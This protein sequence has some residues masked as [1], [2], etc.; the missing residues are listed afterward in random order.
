MMRTTRV[1]VFCVSGIETKGNRCDGKYLY[2]FADFRNSVMWVK[3]R[4]DLRA[5]VFAWPRLA[6]PASQFCKQVDV[7]TP[8]PCL[9]SAANFDFFPIFSQRPTSVLCIST[10]SR[11][12][13]NVHR[14][15]LQSTT[16]WDGEVLLPPP[17][18]P[19]SARPDVPGTPAV[20][21]DSGC[22]AGGRSSVASGLAAVSA[23]A[24]GGCGGSPAM[25][26]LTATGSRL[27]PSSRR[28]CTRSRTSGVGGGR[29]NAAQ[30]AEGHGERGVFGVRASMFV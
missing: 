22:P 9:L 4:C 19:A 6:S 3:R 14:P 28:R 18:V 21:G 11:I 17:S 13:A 12:L 26:A 1:L 20:C 24:G 2:S 25:T 30:H 8:P 5:I 29:E 15:Y 16:R 23:A 7:L 10:P 27:C